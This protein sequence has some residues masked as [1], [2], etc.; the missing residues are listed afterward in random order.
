MWQPWGC[1]SRLSFQENCYGKQSHLAASGYQNFGI[2]RDIHSKITLA[3]S[4]S[5]P[6]TKQDKR[7]RSR[8]V[9]PDMG[10]LS[11]SFF[12]QGLLLTL[13]DFFRT[14]LW[15]EASP[16]QLTSH[17]SGIDVRPALCQTKGKM[18]LMKRGLNPSLGESGLQQYLYVG[19]KP[20]M[21]KGREMGAPTRLKVWSGALV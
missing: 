12:A 17:S 18:S 2:Y 7:T 8:P 14:S 11:W 3:S 5:Q 15:S 16:T 9:L 13:Q 6:I 4:C 20:K 10:V 19:Q 1:V 21:A